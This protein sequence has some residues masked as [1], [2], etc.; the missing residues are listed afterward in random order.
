M[1][2][3]RRLAPTL[4]FAT[5]C[6]A[7]LIVASC[8]DP[9]GPDVI[10]ATFT[11]LGTCTG[12]STTPPTTSVS[13]RTLT[14]QHRVSTPEGGYTFTSAGVILPGSS[15]RALRVTTQGT[16]TQ[17]GLT[18]GTCYAYSVAVPSLPSGSYRMRVVHILRGTT[19]DS[20]AEQSVTI[21]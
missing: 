15:P 2:I 11:L 9:A 3:R 12:T 10:A 14:V 8:K 20:T 21:P 19:V 6:A 5:S 13:G 7:S 18:I 1:T 4:V 16:V 17:P